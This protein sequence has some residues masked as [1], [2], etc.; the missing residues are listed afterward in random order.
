VKSG[1]AGFLTALVGGSVLYAGSTNTVLLFLR[2]SM[3][4]YVIAAG[5]VLVIAGLAA[6]V[7]DW[8]AG[9][10][11]R[12]RVAATVPAAAVAHDHAAGSNEHLA[13][14][15]FGDEVDGAPALAAHPAG[16]GWLLLFPLLVAV[17]VAPGALGA[18]A[19]SHH[20]GL[21][22]APSGTLDVDALL[23][24]Q[25]I[26]GGVPNIRVYDFTRGASA[27]GSRAQLN[28]V[29]VSVQAFVTTSTK[30]NLVLGRFVV[31]CCAA[32]AQLVSI[33]VRGAP[34]VLKPNTWVRVTLAFDEARS[35]AAHAIVNGAVPVARLVKVAVIRAPSD[36]Y[37][38]LWG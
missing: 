16:I 8:R 32:D 3:R 6:V 13:A 29:H 17:F 26:T 34:P 9:R 10:R 31:S 22:V 1:D 19:A 20:S 21:V 33:D 18:Y 35:P 37:E 14:D 24:A 11:P 36:P 25:S 30:T 15:E 4:P 28:G 5:L 12:R 38:Y 2:P 27:D 7:M 23:R